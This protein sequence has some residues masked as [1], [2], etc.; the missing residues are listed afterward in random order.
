LDL[1]VSVLLRPEARLE[2]WPRFTTLSALAVCHAIEAATDLKAKIK[3]PNDVYVQDRKVAGILAETFQDSAGAFMVVGVGLNVNSVNLPPDLR[4]TA[5]SLKLAAG[6]E[7]DRTTLAIALLKSLDA[8]TKGFDSGFA[9]VLEEVRSRS[10]LIGRPLTALVDGQV[11]QGVAEGLNAE[12]HL[13][14]RD[15]RGTLRALSSAEQVR[16]VA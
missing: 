8:L 6:R 1:A 10:W 3:W 14:M 5:G 4:A 12:G 7:V 13:L 9:E 2:W 15:D 11:V 16:P